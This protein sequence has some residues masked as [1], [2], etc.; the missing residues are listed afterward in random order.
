MIEI[1]QKVL[2]LGIIGTI[3]VQQHFQGQ[4]GYFSRAKASFNREQYDQAVA[5]WMPSTLGEKQEIV[6][7]I[8]RKVYWPACQPFLL[9]R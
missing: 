8:S 9:N 7:M 4:L 3:R 2:P 6:D 5:E 1:S